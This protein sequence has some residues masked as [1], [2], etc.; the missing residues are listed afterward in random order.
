[1]WVCQTCFRQV[2]L[3]RKHLARR[4]VCPACGTVSE[5]AEMGPA[6]ELPVHLSD[7]EVET[8]LA[9]CRACPDGH[10]TGE[11]CRIC[12]GC[13]SLRKEN[14][15]RHVRLRIGRCPARHW[16]EPKCVPASVRYI[17][18]QQRVADTLNLVPK[19]PHDLAAI[20]GVARSGLAPATE[21]A[22]ALHLPLFI[23]S[24]Q[25]GI[26]DPGHG[27]RLAGHEPLGRGPIL[28]VDDSRGTGRSQQRAM[29]VARRHWPDQE[30][31]FAVIYCN[32]HSL[33]QPPRPDLW[34]VE[35]GERH[36]FEWNLFNS[37][38]W[39]GQIAYDFD[40][41]L[42]R[43]NAPTI[44]AAVPLH[45]PRRD[46]IP[47]I[48]T[49][50]HESVRKETDAWLAKWRVRV[51]KLVMWPGGDLFSETNGILAVSRYKAEQYAAA[52]RLTLFVESDPR[53]AQE[54]ARLT[55]KAVLCPA[56]EQVY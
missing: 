27:Y 34:S 2:N 54:I 8:R 40:G 28:V 53:Q 21:L 14:F 55:G 56:T 3:R 51:R 13:Q 25:N 43:D 7:A 50:R 39:A 32:V 31:L 37:P 49:G 35:L 38:Y 22:M 9:I 20:C 1:M 6:D 30:L 4:I 17:T 45:L 16:P 46:E 36:L 44:E 24:E 29:P 19:L 42:C 33:G 26:L 10:F 48:V 15:E 47:L 18:S 41:V 12:P 52:P 5:P 11:Y 23:L